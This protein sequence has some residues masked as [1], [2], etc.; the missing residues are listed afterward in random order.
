MPA[1]RCGASEGGHL[2]KRRSAQSESSGPPATWRRE[3]V[4]PAR[5][6]AAVWGDGQ[7]T[8]WVAGS[9]LLLRRAPGA[10]WTPCQVRARIS[11]ASVHGRDGVV[12]AGGYPNH[13]VVS[14]DGHKFERLQ[15]P[16]RDRV[17]QV[18]VLRGG[19]LLV[20]TTGELHTSD[21]GGQR[22]STER[23]GGS[24][25]YELDD[26][27]LW[28]AS[29][30]YLY[31][32]CDGGSSWKRRDLGQPSHSLWGAGDALLLCRWDSDAQRSTWKRSVDRGRSWQEVV[33]PEEVYGF[34]AHGETWLVVGTKG[35]LARSEDRGQ[36]WR[37]ERVGTDRTLR[38]AWVDAHRACLVGDDG[39][40]LISGGDE[41]AP[42]REPAPAPRPARRAAPKLPAL[43]LT[44]ASAALEPAAWTAPGAPAQHEA[45][46]T[47]LWLGP[48]LLLSGDAAGR[49]VTWRLTDGRW[50]A[51]NAREMEAPVRGLVQ[52][53]EQT[54]AAAGE[55]LLGWKGAGRPRA[56]ALPGE[57]HGLSLRSG[58]LF[59]WCPPALVVVEGGRVSG[60]WETPLSEGTCD[61]AADGERWVVSGQRLTWGV[62][63]TVRDSVAAP[64]V[65]ARWLGE[66]LVCA[67]HDKKLDLRAPGKGS[68]KQLSAHLY[69]GPYLTGIPSAP[70][71]DPQAGRLAWV[72]RDGHLRVQQVETG[73]CVGALARS[74]GESLSGV[75][76]EVQATRRAWGKHELLVEDR[77]VETTC[78]ALGGGRV[79]V[80]DQ[81]GEVAVLELETLGVQALTREGGHVTQPRLGAWLYR[82]P[83]NAAAVQGESLFA[84]GA[85]RRVIEVHLD[86]GEAQALP[87]VVDKGLTDLRRILVTD[88]LL[89][90][91]G[92]SAWVAYERSGGAERF[93]TPVPLERM[94]AWRGALYGFQRYEAYAWG[95]RV[96][97]V[98][99]RL[100]L[101]TGRLEQLEPPT[102]PGANDNAGWLA[103]LTPLAEG[104]LCTFDYEG[105]DPR[106]FL[107]QRWVNADVIRGWD[108]QEYALG[109]FLWRPDEG[110]LTPCEL[111][112][113]GAAPELHL[114]Q[115]EAAAVSRDGR[116]GLWSEDHSWCVRDY[117]SA[118]RGAVLAS[119]Q[120]G[121]ALAFDAPARRVLVHLHQQPTELRDFEGR[122]LTRYQSAGDL[123]AGPARGLTHVTRAGAGGLWRERLT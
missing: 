94:H 18:I 80:G 46:V 23:F 9:E 112:L 31:S 110:S 104:L 120:G 83:V 55:R 69:P 20:R 2:T 107:A 15:L 42:G 90:A 47:A 22:W 24:S 103:S 95:E 61:V 75:A 7:G 101:A 56:V 16:S 33:G 63:P 10:A 88:E 70:A 34:A 11:Y 25:V 52:D 122:V 100:D 123:F 96:G 87:I 78:L 51:A 97:H 6:L 91:C 68:G 113:P 62:G 8:V 92:A 13:L 71:V 26:G 79:A 111:V 117:G 37:A 81:H 105:T 108:P 109:S 53:G 66:K 102:P 40:L 1:G 74:S 29:G 76:R 17:D 35:Y 114:G 73:A 115:S 50:E 32:S 45:P 89:I 118:A 54:W 27:S 19:R 60:R 106:T 93:R 65:Q 86:R 84:L 39:L 58:R 85:E 64:R 21:D 82:Q 48:E 38:G 121:R 98:P 49:V 57:A 116:Y 41:S 12:L 67:T 3:L 4:T 28:S 14:R 77:S 72:D 43:E 30:I 44:A 99:F 119:G 59:A 36:S 5:S